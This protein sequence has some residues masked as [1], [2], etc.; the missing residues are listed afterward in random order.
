MEI[1]TVTKDNL[2]NEHICCAISKNKDCQVVAKKSWLAER[3]D[4]GIV[5]KK[6]DVRGKCFIEY[7]PAEKAWSPIKAD[8]YMYIDCF[9]VSG[10]FKGHGNSNIL[11]E[12]CIRDSKEKGRQGLVVLSSKKKMPFLS[13]GKYLRYKGFQLADTAEPFYELLYLPFNNSADKP[14]FNESV[15]SPKIGE[16]GF[17]LYYAYQ[18]PFTAKYVPLIETIA[19]GKGVPFKAVRFETTEQ[20]QNAHAPFTSYSLFF[21]GEFITN[22]ILSEKKFEKLIA[23][24]GF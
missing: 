15:K 23:E 10:Q 22:E 13:D 4:D 21:N 3:F 17:V 20:A 11:L 12:E 2:E 6:G 5:F 24:K 9:W 1:I 8:G 7:I 16:T 19:K 18:C 14:C